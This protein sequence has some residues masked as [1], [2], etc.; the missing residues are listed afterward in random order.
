MIIAV[1]SGMGT[2]E[3]IAKICES[4]SNMVCAAS[5]TDFERMKEWLAAYFTDVVVIEVIHGGEFAYI[6]PIRR[7]RPKMPIAVISPVTDFAY[8]SYKNDVFAYISHPHLEETL[9]EKLLWIESYK[10]LATYERERIRIQTFG[11]F[12][13]FVDGKGVKFTR[14]ISK[15]IL[16][17]LVDKRGTAVTMSELEAITSEYTT[18]ENSTKTLVRIAISELKKTLLSVGAEFI[19]EKS[20]NTIRIVPGTFSCDYYDF[21]KGD[22]ATINSFTGEYMAN[23]SWAEFTGAWLSNK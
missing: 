23:Y 12:D 22:V 11:N 4:S 15:E 14:K 20:Y 1:L 8:E 7:I 13:M 17:Y 6:E 18:T 3:R 10:S 21:L 19:I 16:A 9:A 2:A 5:F